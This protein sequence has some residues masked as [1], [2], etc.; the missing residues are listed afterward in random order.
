MGKSNAQTFSYRW[1]GKQW[2]ID[3]PFFGTIKKKK[4][5][6]ASPRT[7]HMNNNPP[8]VQKARK[9]FEFREMKQKDKTRSTKLWGAIR[10]YRQPLVLETWT[11]SQHLETNG[12]RQLFYIQRNWFRKFTPV[13]PK[14]Q[15]E[16]VHEWDLSYSGGRNL[17]SEDLVNWNLFIPHY[18][19][20][21]HT[22]VIYRKKRSLQYS[23][24]LLQDKKYSLEI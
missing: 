18:S 8:L 16:S 6:P 1:F 21:S 23:Q 10:L 12:Y 14:S 19:G 22:N 4:P 13:E 9:L 15:N 5:Y 24:T 11:K 20:G 3:F 7:D 17:S 2:L